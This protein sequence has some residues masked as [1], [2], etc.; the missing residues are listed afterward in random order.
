[1]RLAM[2]G[3]GNCSTTL[4]AGDR[5]LVYTDGVVERR[6]SPVPSPHLDQLTEQLIAST[7]DAVTTE[8]TVRRLVRSILESLDAGL[9][10]DATLV[11]VDYH[12]SE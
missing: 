7:S 9:D 12:G 8:E 4:Q 2:M 3:A 10:D 6:G 11:L 5:L 1:M